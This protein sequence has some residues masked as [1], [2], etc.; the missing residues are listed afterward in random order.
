MHSRR[1]ALVAATLLLLPITAQAQSRFELSLYPS[2][3]VITTAGDAASEPR[4][5]SYTPGGSLFV[6]LTPY[7]GLEADF[8]GGRGNKQD[9]GSFGRASSPPMTVL[10][11]NALVTVPTR[12]N[13]TP[14]ATVGVGNI[15]MFSREAI[16]LDQGVS[17][18]SVNAGGGAKIMFGWWGIR[19]DYRYVVMEALD[20]ETSPA[21]LGADTRRAHRIAVGLT[22]ALGR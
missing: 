19:A 6:R 14:Y 16:G 9:L 18:A 20:T 10:M 3:R 21:F 11:G 4:F 7:F 8:S 5:K 15:H 17:L 22:L 1:F 12:S 13:V 2:S